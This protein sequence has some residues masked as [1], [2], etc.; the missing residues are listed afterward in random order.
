ME[1]CVCVRKGGVGVYMGAHM[2]GGDMTSEGGINFS[3]LFLSS[4]V[5][6]SGVG[7]C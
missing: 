4:Y 3:P 5:S 2:E 6:R 1:M 7:G